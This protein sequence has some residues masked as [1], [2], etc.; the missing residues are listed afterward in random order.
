MFYKHADKA[1]AVLNRIMGDELAVIV[2]DQKGN[3][4]PLHQMVSLA[5]RTAN[6]IADVRRAKDQGISHILSDNLFVNNPEVIEDTVLRE[7]ISMNSEIKKSSELNTS[8]LLQI[9]HLVDYYNSLRN[10]NT[11]YIQP[12]TYSDKS[13]H[14]LYRLNLS[15]IKI[16]NRTLSSILASLNTTFKYNTSGVKNQNVEQSENLIYE[17]IRLKRL[18]AARKT[19]IDKINRFSKAL[20]LNTSTDTDLDIL[21]SI[22]IINKK[23]KD[24]TSSTENPIAYISDLFYNNNVD[25]YLE[26]DLDSDYGLNKMAVFQFKT[27]SDLNETRLYFERVKLQ[28]VKDLVHSGYEMNRFLDPS[29]KQYYA[30]L[31]ASTKKQ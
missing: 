26:N 11:I 3:K 2:T 17:E 8:E 16:G 25:F 30:T 20:N 9:S 10:D 13:R 18:T 4:L 24:I 29:L 12:M 6:L 19:L 28:Y 14:L 27:F 1:A 15:K 21:N 31:D 5:Y 7:S 22:D 23:I